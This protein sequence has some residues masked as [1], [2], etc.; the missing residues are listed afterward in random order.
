MGKPQGAKE[1]KARAREKRGRVRAR[2][3]GRAKANHHGRRSPTHQKGK[4]KRGKGSPAAGTGRTTI[5]TRAAK[6]R[7]RREENHP[8]MTGSTTIILMV[9]QRVA[10]KGN[11]KAKAQT[12]AR[13]KR[14]RVR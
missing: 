12:K 2:T 9:I 14:G 11:R 13:E 3:K 1:R 4:A 6:G 10:K 8:G 5:T 7:A